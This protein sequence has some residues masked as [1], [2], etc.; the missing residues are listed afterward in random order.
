MDE[1]LERLAR[2]Y[3]AFAE[4]EAAE[5][6]PLYARLAVAV[7]EDEAILRFLAGLPA[8]KR[9][10]NLLFAA[11]QYLH[12]TAD[13]VATF[14]RWVTEDA[15]RVRTTMLARATQTNEPARCTALLPL[16]DAVPGPLALIEVG[17]SAGLCLYPDRYAYDYDGTRLGPA[18]PV[19]LTCRVRGDGPLP[20]RL[21]DVRARLGID[22]N[23]LD[24]T[25]P[26]VR[27]WL[28]AL[29]WPGP[30]A[31]ARLARL[32][33]AAEIAR[34]EPP[35]ILAGDLIE[36]LPDALELVP[37]GCTPVV[38]STAVLIYLPRARRQQFA[39]LVRSLPVRWIAQEGPGALPDVAAALPPGEEA[40]GRFLLSLDG[41]PL[42]WTA[43]H[44]GGIDWLP[45][46]AALAHPTTQG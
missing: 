13:G 28:R 1:E 17:A 33:A 14:R 2:G 18:S 9:Q 12:G 25:D 5:A 22:L 19:L 16:L 4:V 43:P 40:H 38:F 36:R 21:P 15:D 46:A 8:G 7:A 24:V 41:A 6:S 31:A 39:E 37:P 23:P 26:D 30:H 11:V 34:C 45:G 27:A 35:R 10:P 32:D 29:V 42:A 3:R 44:G 20:S